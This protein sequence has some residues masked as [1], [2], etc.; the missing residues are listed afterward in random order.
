MSLV[1]GTRV[2]VGRQ[3]GETWFSPSTTWVQD[4]TQV[5]ELDVK[6]TPMWDSL[7]K[8]VLVRDDLDQAGLSGGFLDGHSECGHGFTG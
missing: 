1:P 4:P 8:S 3:L 6:P 7:S 2:K 5:V